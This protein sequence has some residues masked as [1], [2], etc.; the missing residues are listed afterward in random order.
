MWI[1]VSAFLHQT[2]QVFTIDGICT[3][4]MHKS[5][6]SR[7]LLG[8]ILARGN[9]KPC[10]FIPFKRVSSGMQNHGLTSPGTYRIK[11]L[12]ID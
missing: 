8:T 9:W 5:P 11:S 7:Y 12:L 2:K 1:F 4:L 3:T 10:P 6:Q